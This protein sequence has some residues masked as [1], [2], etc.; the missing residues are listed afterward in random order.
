M[1]TIHCA[2]YINIA[3]MLERHAELCRNLGAQ[4]L[5][6]RDQRVQLG[7]I[8]ID[9]SVLA[10]NVGLADRLCEA[11]DL[12]DSH[13]AAFMFRNMLEHDLKPRTFLEVAADFEN[14]LA[15]IKREAE[16]RL[17]LEVPAA[18]TKYVGQEKP[19]GEAVYSSFPSAR[20]DL[21]QA[22]NCLAYGCNT[23]ATFH[24][25]RAAEI[26]LRELGRDRQI[27]LAANGKI[28]FAQ[29]GTIISGL[30][31]AIEDIQQWPNGRTKEDA[32]KFYNSALVEIRA[33]N[34][35]WRRHAVHPRPQQPLLQD[36]EALA[37][38]GHVGRFLSS[39]ATRIGEGTYTSLIW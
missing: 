24:L 28:E 13:M 20:A 30:E 8:V 9:R 14:L 5:P 22:G 11:F 15:T 33:F 39:L 27:P 3:T 4:Q 6:G 23:A 21:T 36:E 16:K 37:L 38:H 7:N 31:T 29:W 17:Y 25:M 10:A 12:S 32:H 19:L 26:G 2:E 1:K 35:G 18:L 34:D